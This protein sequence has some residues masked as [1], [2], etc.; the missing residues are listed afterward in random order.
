M[1]HEQTL[2]CLSV[3]V[4]SMLLILQICLTGYAVVEGDPADAGLSPGTVTLQDVGPCLRARSG[5]CGIE[6]AE[7]HACTAASQHKVSYRAR[8]GGNA[9]EISGSI[10]GIIYNKNHK[11]VQ[12]KVL[13]VT[14]LCK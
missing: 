12:S 14:W 5:C 1:K 6:G 10:P 11:H 4:C 2:Q 8:E 3:R 13:H 7:L 9:T